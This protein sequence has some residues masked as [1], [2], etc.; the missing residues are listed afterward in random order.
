MKILRNFQ[1]INLTKLV[2][3]V[4]DQQQHVD[5]EIFGILKYL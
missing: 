2:N 1:I 5:Y 3:L 4:K